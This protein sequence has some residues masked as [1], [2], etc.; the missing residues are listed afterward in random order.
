MKHFDQQ[1]ILRDNQQGSRKKHSCQIQIL[2]TVQEIA[3][4]AAKG[5][6]VDII[7]FDFEKAFDKIAHSMSLYRLDHYG[8]SNNIKNMDTI[9]PQPHISASH[10]GWSKDSS[11]TTSLSLR[12]QGPTSVGTVL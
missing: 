5:K 10:T 9:L 1:N 4:S 12:H 11:Q 2:F 8:V 6:Q 7:L 3:S